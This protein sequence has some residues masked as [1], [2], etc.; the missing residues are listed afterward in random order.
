MT[1]QLF[2]SITGYPGELDAIKQAS[3]SSQCAIMFKLTFNTISSVS[4][5]PCMH[6]SCF[7]QICMFDKA[8]YV[9]ETNTRGLLT[10]LVKQLGSSISILNT[11]IKYQHITGRMQNSMINVRL[12]SEEA[13]SFLILYKN[14][15][16]V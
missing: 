3:F 8:R 10:S 14:F 5:V 7:I 9:C 1:G 6:C 16:G 13:N 15:H 2:F 4:L 11:I 12:L